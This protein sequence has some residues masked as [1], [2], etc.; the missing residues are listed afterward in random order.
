MSGRKVWAT[1]VAL[2]STYVDIRIDG[3]WSLRLR[4][5][6]EEDH[7]E[8]ELFFFKRTM[9]FPLQDKRNTCDRAKGLCISSERLYRG[10]GCRMT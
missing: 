4:A 5:W 6:T 8:K 1:Y 2:I 10:A 3:A 9:L 7:Y